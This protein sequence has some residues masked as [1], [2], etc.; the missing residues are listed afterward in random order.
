M[1]RNTSHYH[2]RVPFEALV[3]PSFYL[4]GK[5]IQDDEPHL[6]AS[7]SSS[8][9][10]PAG[11]GETYRLAMHNFLAE[12]PNFFLENAKLTTFASNDDRIPF[13]VEKATFANVEYQ[14]EYRM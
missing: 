1:A 2:E 12:V 9:I 11:G 10:Y 8:A 13:S 14:K 6:S 7:L 5:T 4:A 3:D